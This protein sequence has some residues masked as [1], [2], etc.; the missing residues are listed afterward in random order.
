[1]TIE[2]RV[3]A[4][5]ARANPVPSLDLLDAIPVEVGHLESRSER[6]SMTEVRTAEPGE[7]RRTPRLLLVPALAAVVVVGLV[8][9][10]FLN[11]QTSVAADTPAEAVA[12]AYLDALAR[13]DVEE[14]H[15]LVA[16]TS[17]VDWNDQ[18]L[19]QEWRRAAGIVIT[20]MDCTQRPESGPDGAL[21]D[22]PWT[23]D[24]DWHRA[25]GLEPSSMM[26]VFLIK[27][28][29][30]LE[31]SET[32]IDDANATLVWDSFRSWVEFNHGADVATMYDDE[33]GGAHLTQQS[34]ALWEQYTDE[35]VTEM[36]SRD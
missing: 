23:Y 34:I 17:D 35:Y 9:A 30:I 19:I 20:R 5:F 16:P 1:V 3:A 21:V 32:N 25:L 31:E 26:Q 6:N 28:G 36:E 13:N 10:A 4:M 14:L 8:V 33:S 11:R 7:S 15:E 24:S 22:C 2:D 27:D 29:K 12:V 18:S